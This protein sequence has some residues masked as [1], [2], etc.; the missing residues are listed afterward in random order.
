MLPLSCSVGRL[1]SASEILTCRAKTLKPQVAQPC[2]DAV[3]QQAFQALPVFSLDTH[4]G[5]EGEAPAMLPLAHGRGVFPFEQIEPA[6][7]PQ[8]T[9]ADPGL[10]FGQRFGA[11]GARFR[12][13]AFL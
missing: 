11:K 3:A 8:Q 10:Y 1:E 13:R 4:A 2:P 6:Q 7:R 5:I 12:R 9:G